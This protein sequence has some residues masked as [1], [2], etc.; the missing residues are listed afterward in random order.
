LKKYLNV[1]LVDH[2]LTRVTLTTLRDKKTS[3]ATFRMGLVQLGH[4]MGIEIAGTLEYTEIEVETPLGIKAGGISL[5][6]AQNV[7]I[8]NIL[9]A[10]MPFVEGLLKAL[11]AARQSVVGAKR[12]EEGIAAPGYNF[13]IEMY[14]S[15]ISRIY[16]RDTLIIADP[17]LAS[18]CTI[19]AVL[20]EIMVKYSPKRVVVASVIAAP[21][22]VERIIEKYPEIEIFTVAVD[23]GLDEHGYIV[24]GLGDAGDRAFG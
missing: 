17:M 1:K 22:G 19:M 3:Q 12:I 18:G 8:V 2:P 7:V 20:D 9:R 16:P 24:P 6:D 21:L 13:R 23:E 15:K 10:A 5:A 14:Y 4:L 11:P